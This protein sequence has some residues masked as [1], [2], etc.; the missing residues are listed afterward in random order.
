MQ[1]FDKKSNESYLS[2]DSAVQEG[3][4]TPKLNSEMIGINTIQPK[5]ND[6]ITNNFIE[7]RVDFVSHNDSIVTNNEK[8]RLLKTDLSQEI[9]LKPKIMEEIFSHPSLSEKDFQHIN[10]LKK[11]SFEIN[12]RKKRRKKKL[13]LKQPRER[14]AEVRETDKPLEKKDITFS[15][16]SAEKKLISP[17]GRIGARHDSQQIVETPHY[18]GVASGKNN[19]KQRNENEEKFEQSHGDTIQ[20]QTEVGHGSAF[21]EQLNESR[22]VNITMGSADMTDIM[23]KN[24]KIL[25]SEP[26]SVEKKKFRSPSDSK[27]PNRMT[28]PVQD[29]EGSIGFNS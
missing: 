19:K 2:E 22:K 16:L 26:G 9:I 11:Q 13:P 28:S 20:N 15:E 17:Q 1:I 12:Q 3:K 10:D 29:S 4:A 21:P 25:A 5:K 18:G 23:L 14:S 24:E 6:P 27:S 8:E 7:E